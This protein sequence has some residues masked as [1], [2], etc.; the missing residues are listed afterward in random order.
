VNQSVRRFPLFSKEPIVQPLTTGEYTIDLHTSISPIIVCKCTQLKDIFTSAADH[1][2]SNPPIHVTLYAVKRK[3]EATTEPPKLT[4]ATRSK[5]KVYL[6]D[7][8][9][10]P[11]V[12]QTS[13][14]MAALLS[15]LYTLAHSANQKG[16]GGMSNILNF[17]YAITRFP[18][19]VRACKSFGLILS[20]HPQLTGT[21]SIHSAQE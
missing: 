20:I 18:P 19:A 4:F 16:T 17:L 9:W 6:A 3:N 2:A 13:R 11:S 14:G 5:E 21:Y 15:S 7:S 12:L 1:D 8:A 10:Q